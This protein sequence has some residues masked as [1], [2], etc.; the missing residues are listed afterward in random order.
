LAGALLFDEKFRHSAALFWFG[1][2]DVLILLVSLSHFW[3][4][5]WQKRFRFEPMQTMIQASR[6]L[7]SF[8]QNFELLS[9]I[10]DQKVKNHKTIAVDVLF[11]AFPMVPL[12]CRSNLARQYL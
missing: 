12:S 11:K 8:L 7:D 9:S 6:R 5:V 4:T 2:R 10:Q 1:L 3:S